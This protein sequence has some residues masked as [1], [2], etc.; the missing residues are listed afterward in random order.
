MIASIKCYKLSSTSCHLV[1]LKLYD[2]V[3]TN[4]FF[5]QV[6]DIAVGEL[7]A[8]TEMEESEMGT[9]IIRVCYTRR[10]KVRQTGIGAFSRELEKRK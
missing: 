10:T 6:V 1:H 9:D 5:L 7:S 3:L 4:A 2:C 8:N